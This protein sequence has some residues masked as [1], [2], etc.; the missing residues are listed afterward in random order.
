[1]TEISYKNIQKYDL[2]KYSVK[3]KIIVNFKSNIFAK[4][5]FNN[6]LNK[7]KIADI[8][9]ESEKAYVINSFRVDVVGTDIE[10]GFFGLRDNR[11]II[12]LEKVNGD[13]VV[14]SLFNEPKYI[15]RDHFDVLKVLRNST[16]IT[17]VLSR[18]LPPI[19][20]CK[21]DEC[22]SINNVELKKAEVKLFL[23]DS[24]LRYFLLYISTIGAVNLNM[25]WDYGLKAAFNA[26][27]GVVFVIYFLALYFEFLWFLSQD[28]FKLEIKEE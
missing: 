14:I 16:V 5:A 26:G 9:D 2:L 27:S 4:G 19:Y 8:G 10:I 11:P 17:K 18:F 24:L 15:M 12:I 23:K 7:L 13:E 28:R 6:F 3:S 1:M 25:M 22:V 21:I 20:P